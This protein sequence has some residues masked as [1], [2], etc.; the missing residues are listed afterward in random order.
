MKTVLTTIILVLV[1][2]GI[3]FLLFGFADGDQNNTS[4]DDE[5][6]EQTNNQR[7]VTSNWQSYQAETTNDT[8]MR[9]RYPTEVSV[10]E[11]QDDIYEIKYIGPNSEE[12]TEITDGYYASFTINQSANLETYADEQGPTSRVQSL[13]FNGHEAVTYTTSSELGGDDI[14]H[15]TYQ[16]FPDSNLTVDVAYSTYGANSEQYENELMAVLNTLSFERDEETIATKTIEIAVLNLDG[17]ESDSGGEIRGCDRV[18]MVEEIIPATTQP[19]NAAIRTLFT[20]E[21]TDVMGWYNFIAE[22]NDTLSFDRATLNDQGIASI[23]LEGELT[24]LTGV[25]DNPRA[26][27]QIEETA[28]QFDTVSGVELYLNGVRTELQP[29]L[30]GQAE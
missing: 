27:I 8:T 1:I 17:Q 20:Y 26:K 21:S 5:Q 14:T 4:T 28:L 9:L 10:T 30:S 3:A 16:P 2:G 13:Q 22:T 24:G 11:V 15:I 25:C 19:L 29:D 12:A 18:I 23:Y 7:G 6:K